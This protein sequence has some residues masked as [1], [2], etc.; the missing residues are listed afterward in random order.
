MSEE[1]K[2]AELLPTEGQKVITMKKLLEAGVHFGHNTRRWNPKMA[3]YIYTARNGIYILD[4]EKSMN[5]ID[6]AYK[7][8][9]KIVD[10][11]G[12]I[13]FVGTKKQVQEA[14]KEEALR[15]GSFYVSSRWLGGALTNFKTIQKRI[16]YLKDIE[17]ME[18]DGNFDVLPKKEVANLRKEAE[19]L[20]KVLGGI[21]EMR[22]IPNAMV[23]VD[24]KI[25]HNA[26]AEARKL[27]I[28]VF[29]V[30]DTNGDPDETDYV[31]PGNDDATRSVKLILTVL[32]DA[33]VESK[34][35]QT[36]VAYVKDEDGTEVS[37]TDAIKS[38]DRAEE[39]RRAARAQNQER[40]FNNR[41]PYNSNGPRTDRPAGTGDRKPY[42]PRPNGERKPYTPRP[43]SDV[44]PVVTEDTTSKE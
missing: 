43:T 31:I 40:R 9:K 1:I 37:M 20:E 24:P 13:L 42:T 11:G 21:K 2:M 19:K 27:G 10:D 39:A 35:G 34:G 29:G 15:S 23:V 44:A 26:V 28:P 5:K 32:A 6:E 33:V 17:K 3:K 30:I 12:K 41:R 38:V 7:A 18:E 36:L 14:V 8:L 25:E 4:L 16:K 22:K